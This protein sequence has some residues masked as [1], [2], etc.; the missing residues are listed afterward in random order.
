MIVNANTLC[1]PSQ[2]Y[3]ILSFTGLLLTI[4][5]NVLSA[6]HCNIRDNV[7]LFVAQFLYLFF[8]SWFLNQICKLGYKKVS[9]F[10]FLCPLIVSFAMVA[11]FYFQ[12]N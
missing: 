8:W 7:V 2:Y 10:L 9:W 4:T 5:L 12:I 6:S 11:I 1:K 3:F